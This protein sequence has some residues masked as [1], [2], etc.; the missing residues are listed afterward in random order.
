ML[1][2]ARKPELAGAKN[3]TGE[4]N[5]IARL[6]LFQLSLAGRGKAGAT[7]W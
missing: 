1:T 2:L 5:L 6:L 3:K 7:S 4:S